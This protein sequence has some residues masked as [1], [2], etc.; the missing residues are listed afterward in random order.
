MI[1]LCII[2]LSVHLVQKITYVFEDACHYSGHFRILNCYIG[3]NKLDITKKNLFN[4]IPVTLSSIGFAV[5]AHSE[6]E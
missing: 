3:T 6:I 1:I 4:L 2:Y 5:F